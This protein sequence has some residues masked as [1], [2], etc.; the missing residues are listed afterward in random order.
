[1]QKTW[2]RSLG[3]EDPLEKE[4]ATLSSILAWRI[5]WTE[6][7]GGLLSMGLQRVGHDW[8]T[9]LSFFLLPLVF[10]LILTVASRLLHL[11]SKTMGCLSGCLISSAS[12]QKLFCRICSVLKYSFNEFVWEKVVSLSYSSAILGPP[13]VSGFK[14]KTAKHKL[15]AKNYDWT[16]HKMLQKNPNEHFGQANFLKQFLALS[17]MS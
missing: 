8:A 12:I 3:P 16:I 17:R 10:S 14:S 13:S 9:S 1:M 5:P 6:D 4:M 7:P 2:V 15:F 11:L